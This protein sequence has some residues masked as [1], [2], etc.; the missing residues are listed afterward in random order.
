MS[1][2]FNPVVSSTSDGSDVTL[3]RILDATSGTNMGYDSI[4]LSNYTGSNPGT[5]EYRLNGSTIR[6]ITLTW[7]GNNLSS[8]SWS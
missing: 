3:C 7:D 1:R 8:V 6:T 2:T 4:N 5:I